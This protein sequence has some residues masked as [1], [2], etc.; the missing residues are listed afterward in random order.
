MAVDQRSRHGVLDFQQYRA[1]ASPSSQRRRLAS[2]EQK[3]RRPRSPGHRH[4]E[5][6]PSND[7]KI[8]HP[9]HGRV[10]VASAS[11]PSSMQPRRKK[12]VRFASSVKQHDGLSPHKRVFDEVV[13]DLFNR[14]DDRYRTIRRVID[15]GDLK[16]LKRLQ[17]QLME[18]MNRC[19]E[20][21]TPVLNCGGGRNNVVDERF[22]PWLFKLSERVVSHCELIKEHHLRTGNSGAPT[23][24]GESF[25]I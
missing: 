3:H 24:L 14:P 25:R 20:G 1:P 8:G 5:R 13:H 10:R 4:H 15:E 9:K 18:L 17:E 21:K 19:S 12:S 11:P 22:A 7:R 23:G 16:I 6:T 2:K